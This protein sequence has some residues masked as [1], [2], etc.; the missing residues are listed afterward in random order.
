MVCGQ[1]ADRGLFSGCCSD[2]RA[3]R[4]LP[5]R[6]RFQLPHGKVSDRWQDNFPQPTGTPT[7]SAG[8][9]GISRYFVDIDRPSRADSAVSVCP[10]TEVA[11][12]ERDRSPLLTVS[13][14]STGDI[15]KWSDNVLVVAGVGALV[16]VLFS[17]VSVVALPVYAFI[18]RRRAP[19]AFRIGAALLWEVGLV[20]F[21]SAA[22]V[23]ILLWLM[24]GLS[25]WTAWAY[26]LPGR[27]RF[28]PSRWLGRFRVPR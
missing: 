6:R 27:N 9:H 5:L 10:Q 1:S 15:F 26:S 17:V 2:R 7:A 28:E 22:W 8:E 18:L 14:L 4:P 12:V 23:W 19:L 16:V 13:V 20:L 21:T 25:L 24:V 3:T 11:R